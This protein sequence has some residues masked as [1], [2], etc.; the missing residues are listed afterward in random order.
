MR[1]VAIEALLS[2]FVTPLFLA[3]FGIPV[4]R[5]LDGPIIAGTLAGY[6]YFLFFFG[7]GLLLAGVLS[8]FI[9]AAARSSARYVLAIICPTLFIPASVVA[10]FALTPTS[11]PLIH[12]GT[13]YVIVGAVAGLCI[14]L[15]S[16]FLLHRSEMITDVSVSA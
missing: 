10:S 4:R 7:L 3:I 13:R 14:G 16:A 12:D 5:F 2:V 11:V 1:T 8:G 6:I 15:A 9:A